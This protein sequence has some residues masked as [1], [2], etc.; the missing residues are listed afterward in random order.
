MLINNEKSHL[1]GFIAFYWHLKVHILRLLLL[2][3]EI[4]KYSR[5]LVLAFVLKNYTKF[6]VFRRWGVRGE[7]K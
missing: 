3:P 6:A 1:H 5:P 7:T 4:V 2:V